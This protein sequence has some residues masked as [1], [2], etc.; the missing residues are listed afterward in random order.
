MISNL[1]IN[2]SYGVF[3]ALTCIL[4]SVFSHVYRGS[5]VLERLV[6]VTSD[7][8]LN[9]L[10]GSVIPF[11]MFLPYIRLYILS[12]TAVD[13]V[14]PPNVEQEVERILI[15]SRSAFIMTIFPFVS[16]LLSLRN[17]K[18]MLCEVNIAR[19]WASVSPST[20]APKSTRKNTLHVV[21]YKLRS[22]SWLSRWMHRLLL[23]YGSGILAISI[24][25]S[26]LL[27]H[28]Q[29]DLYTCDHRVYPWMTSKE[30]CSGRTI[31]CTRA[32]ISGRSGEIMSA[33]DDF[34]PTSLASLIF[35][36][37]TDLQI[38]PSIHRFANL[39]KMMIR[40]SILSEWSS[41]A[42]ISQSF[43]KVIRAVLLTDVLITSEPS[44]LIHSQ[45]PTS[46]E[47]IAINTTDMSIW[48]DG[49]GNNWNTLKYFYC[50]SCN[51]TRF[52]DIVQDMAQ[53][54]EL[55]A[56][57]NSIPSIDDDQ[58]KRLTLLETVWL[59]GSPISHLP[60]ALWRMSSS[61]FEIYFQD[62]KIVSVPSWVSTDANAQF[63]MFGHGTP[64]CTNTTQATLV[65]GLVCE[66]TFF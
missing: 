53:L 9:F 59:D 52:P 64:L 24:A 2:Q 44:G 32:G 51:L 20:C 26:G 40:N 65:R 19:T 47:W 25:A 5:H 31:D 18:I 63:R 6:S 30:A 12:Q 3:L 55:S 60:D 39:R 41:E 43:F 7:L 29:N 45:I 62:T 16:T 56:C 23:L 14:A 15:L 21:A 1:Y 8:T 46:L 4:P 58:I 42:A 36:R 13:F 66:R 28:R 57:Y 22:Y 27:L 10:W 50:D 38:P 61:F 35:E 17:I 11:F 34:D 54:L 37:C 48:I 33:L 49:I